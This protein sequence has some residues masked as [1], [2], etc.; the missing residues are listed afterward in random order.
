METNIR[1]WSDYPLS[2]LN[3]K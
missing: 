3:V 1:C 2:H